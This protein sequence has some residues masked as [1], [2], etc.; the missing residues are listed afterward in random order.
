MTEGEGTYTMLSSFIVTVM[1]DPLCCMHIYTLPLD[2]NNVNIIYPHEITYIV[3]LKSN[4][5]LIKLC[6]SLKDLKM[7]EH[8]FRIK[9]S[10]VQQELVSINKIIQDIRCMYDNELMIEL[11]LSRR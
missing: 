7:G 5:S 9:R 8:S 1:E 11:I 10:Q 3:M 2:R 4:K 6:F